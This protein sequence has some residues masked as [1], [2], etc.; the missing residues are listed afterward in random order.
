MLFLKGCS[1]Y[2]LNLVVVS[3]IITTVDV[4]GDMQICVN[5]IKKSVDVAREINVYVAVYMDTLERI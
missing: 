4:E 5:G 1:S 3:G 2:A